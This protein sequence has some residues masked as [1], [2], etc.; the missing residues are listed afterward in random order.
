M[1]ITGIRH[2]LGSEVDAR[3]S[4]TLLRYL[5]HY[6]QMFA[7]LGVIIPVLAGVDYFLLPETKDE[8][9]TNKFYQVKDN[10]NFEYHFFTESYRF[11]SDIVFYENTNIDDRITLYHTPIFKAITNVS[12][13]VEQGVYICNPANIYGWPFIVVGLTFICSLIM[14][15]RTWGWIQK[16]NHVKYDSVVNLG[17][18]NSFLCVIT[19]IAI[20]F[21]LPY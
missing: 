15:I 21:H 4:A 6:L 13:P 3:R 11:I 19:I 10:L 9:V 18:I 8:I 2:Q 14:I 17:V 1:L 16:R 5:I 12:H 20:L 7:F